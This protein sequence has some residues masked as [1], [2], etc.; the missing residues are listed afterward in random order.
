V[1]FRSTGTPAPGSKGDTVTDETKKPAPDPVGNYAYTVLCVACLGA[2]VMVHLVQPDTPL[3]REIPLPQNKI[4]G[5]LIL[6]VGAM[7]IFAHLRSAPQLLLLIVAAPFLVRIGFHVYSFVRLIPVMGESYPPRP[8]SRSFSVLDILQSCA[9][10]GFTLGHFRLLSIRQNVFPPDPRLRQ[11][12]KGPLKKPWKR[13]KILNPKRSPRL[14][15][16]LELGVALLA[17]PIWAL[18]AQY[19]SMW[20]YSTR[21]M[22]GLTLA[23][24]RFFLTGWL[25]LVPGL[26]LAGLFYLWRQYQMSPEQAELI[27]Q[28]A[29]WQETRREQRRIY[30]WLTWWWIRHKQR[31]EKP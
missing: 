20:L 23:T 10:L 21:P 3:S 1:D 30:R 15:T 4:L 16:L 5:V 18:V 29:L 28:D 6:A 8:F 12:S 14:V 17:L 22:L 27:V 11:E 25:I 31:K 26:V 7:G 13:R 9:M 19:F 24:T 2:L